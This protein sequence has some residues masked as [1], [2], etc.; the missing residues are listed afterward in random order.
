ML[1]LSIR[2]MGAAGMFCSQILLARSLGVAGF[3]EYALAIT[4]LQVLAVLTKLG[5]DNA[6]LRYVAEFTTRHEAEKLHCFSRD[7]TRASLV[8]SVLMMGLVACVAMIFRS[9]LGNGIAGGLLIAALMIPLVSLRQIQEASLRGIGLLFESQIAT[10][11]W[12]W[13]LCFLSLIAWSLSRSGISSQLAVGLHF[14]A[15]GTVSVIVYYYYRQSPLGSKSDPERDQTARQWRSQRRHRRAIE[16]Q[17]AARAVWRQQWKYTAL[18]FLLAEVLIVL[19]SRACIALAGIMLD[20]EAVGLYGAMEKFADVSV[21]AT[22]SLGLVIAPQFAALNAAGRY[23]DMRRLMKQGQILCLCTTLPVAVIV[24]LFGDGI[25]ALLGPGYRDGWTVLMALLA[26]TCIAS[27]SGPAAYILQMTGHERT[28]LVITAAC[29]ATNIVLSLILMRFCGL[30]GLGIA[31]MATSLVWMAGVR[32]SLS[33]HPAWQ[34]P[35]NLVSDSHHR[36]VEVA[37]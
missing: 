18:A 30:L 27:F 6:S 5:L 2:V 9:S 35:S 12:P 37:A 23:V 26:S 36:Q 4:W 25:F 16:N 15:I 33:F 22:Q 3:G 28:M 24:A 13:I 31:Q 29:A 8:I 17:Q 20:R 7:S 1:A 32:Y 14:V 34:S 19:K 11:L 21:L 10:A